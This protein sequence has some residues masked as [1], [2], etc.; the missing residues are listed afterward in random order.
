MLTRQGFFDGLEDFSQI[1]L[2]LLAG[3][4]L[5]VA[6]FDVFVEL[7][8]DLLALGFDLVEFS[9]LAVE[10][11]FLRQQLRLL[12]VDVGFD[13]GQLAQGLIEPFEL[14]QAGLAQVVVIGEGA[15]EFF[16][17]LLVEQHFQVFLTAA[18][19][20]GPGLNGDQ[21]LLFNFC[22]VEFFFL[23]IKAQQL[24]FTLF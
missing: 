13:V 4:Q 7:G 12:L 6:V 16:G 22:A 11:A 8:Q 14:L 23:T 20:R 5:L 18:L 21:A 1:C 9:T 15:G 19:I 10:V 3:L 2:I 17:V 24:A